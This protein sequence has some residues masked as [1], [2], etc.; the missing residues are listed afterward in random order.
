MPQNSTANTSFTRKIIEVRITL[1]AG[2]FGGQGERKILRGLPVEA[3]V[4][5][6]GLPDKNK[7]QVKIY[8]MKY[9]DMEQL[10]TLAFRPLEAR[11]NLISIMAGDEEHGL[12][13][14]FA[15]EIASA[16]ADFNSAPDPAFQIEALSGYYPSLTPEGPQAVTGNAPVAEIIADLAGSMGYAF[17]NEG[18]TARLNNAVL[19]G[20]P[21]EKAR[22]AAAQVGAELLVDDGVL[23]LLPA[24]SARSGEAVP[25]SPSTGLF[26]YP[27]FT[28]DGLSLRALYN[29][30]FRQG[31]LIRVESVVPRASG[32]WKIT[33]LSHRLAAFSPG[34]G[35]WESRIEAIDA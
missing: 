9:E 23:T 13:E 34:G 27:A 20:S 22:A 6:P 17:R 30:S 21:L 24:G 25:L 31:G 2:S 18:V 11:R 14:V 4:D 35:P 29:P 7:A 28:N 3:D 10:T 16:F 8:G 26:G 32:V 5:K 12:S 1:A 33:R 19:N 15:G